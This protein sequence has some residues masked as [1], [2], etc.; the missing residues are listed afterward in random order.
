MSTPDPNPTSQGPQRSVPAA[1]GSITVAVLMAI[2][3]SLISALAAEEVAHS[4]PELFGGLFGIL[5]WEGV[6]R[7]RKHGE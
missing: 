3:G 4:L 5:S 7:L 2:I 1:I 6:H